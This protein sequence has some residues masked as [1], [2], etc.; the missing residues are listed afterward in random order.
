MT[1]AGLGANTF[2]IFSASPRMWRAN[3]PDPGQIRL[4]RAARERYDLT[5]LA[6]H[7]SYLINLAAADPLIRERSVEAF[8]GEVRRALAI[9]AEYLVAHP[10]SYGGQGV[11]GGVRTLAESLRA[12]THGLK[13]KHLTLLFENTAGGGTLLGG[14][15]EELRPIREAVAG[16]VPAGF[17]LDTAHCLAAGYDVASAE[18][19]RSTIR[20]AGR[21]LGLD[22]VRL[23]HANDSKAPLGSRLDRHEHIGAGFIGEEGFRRILAHPKLRAKP[24]IL[25]TPQDREG[26]DRR[27]VETLK[28][29]CRKRPTST[30]RSN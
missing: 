29:L 8:R 5:P 24:F 7:D 13:V 23:I 19:L 12:A 17:C 1:A 14:C 26:D 2:Q 25:E 22:N 15:F 16:D 6:I 21:I 30:K 20:D 9:G 10:G 28:R 4:L 27:D 18:G 11:E 3:D